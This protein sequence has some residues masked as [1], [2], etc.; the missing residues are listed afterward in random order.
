MRSSCQGFRPSGALLAVAATLLLVAARPAS[1]ATRCAQE[2]WDE[3]V[4]GVTIPGWWRQTPGWLQLTGRWRRPRCR[5]KCPVVQPPACLQQVSLRTAAL[6]HWLCPTSTPQPSRR[7]SSPWPPP[8]SAAARLASTC[9]TAPASSAPS[10]PTSPLPAPTPSASSA[11]S[12]PLPT[13]RDPP[14]ALPATSA[15]PW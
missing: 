9:P 6:P 1:A 7:P 3:C 15:S 11:Q 10:T 13:L 2:G 14:P 8:H 4:A 12:P 5:C